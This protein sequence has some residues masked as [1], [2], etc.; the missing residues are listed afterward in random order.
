MLLLSV[1]SPPAMESPCVCACA[2]ENNT[3]KWEIKPNNSRWTSLPHKTWPTTKWWLILN[4]RGHSTSD[5]QSSSSKGLIL[6]R[7]RLVSCYTLCWSEKIYKLLTSSLC[8][9]IVTR[10]A[11]QFVVQISIL[12]SQVQGDW[13]IWALLVIIDWERIVNVVYVCLSQLVCL[14]L[15]FLVDWK[16]CSF[17]FLLCFLVKNPPG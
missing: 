12:K 8:L 14:L 15:S 2:K 11:S 16:I 9:S 1:S 4:I 13:D 3:Q 6:K 5:R 17:V 10:N 7:K